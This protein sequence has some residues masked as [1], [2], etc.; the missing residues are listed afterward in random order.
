MC[1]AAGEATSEK[2][3]AS[4]KPAAGMDTLDVVTEPDAD[5]PISTGAF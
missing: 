4:A 1:D 3:C 5:Q 2:A